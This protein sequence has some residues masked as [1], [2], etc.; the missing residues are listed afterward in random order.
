MLSNANDEVRCPDESTHAEPVPASGQPLVEKD[1]SPLAGGDA[2]RGPR[3][4]PGVKQIAGQQRFAGAP[5]ER[6]PHGRRHWQSEGMTGGKPGRRA[7]SESD[8][9][10]SGIARNPQLAPEPPRRPHEQACRSGRLPDGVVHGCNRRARQ[11]S[12]GGKVNRAREHSHSEEAHNEEP[13]TGMAWILGREHPMI[14][15]EEMA[16]GRHRYGAHAESR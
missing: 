1:H 7:P 2:A 6:D 16:P 13:T 5:G 4:Q 10:G 3:S 9:P 8:R 11:D 12:V 15:D 14:N